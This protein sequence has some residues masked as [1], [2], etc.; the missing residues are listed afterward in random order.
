MVWATRRMVRAV[1]K[2]PLLI[3]S[4][5]QSR[6]ERH[7]AFEPQSITKTRSGPL[8][9]RSSV[10]YIWLGR[11]YLGLRSTTCAHRGRRQ[12]RAPMRPWQKVHNSRHDHAG[13]TRHSPRK[14][15]GS[16]SEARPM[17]LNRVLRNGPKKRT[18][19]CRTRVPP[20]VLGR[21]H[22]NGIHDGGPRSFV[23]LP[24]ADLT[25]G[26]PSR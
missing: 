13:N 11:G 2:Y 3:I 22:A 24:V 15:C 8:H 4:P 6:F 18:D 19:S 9:G 16:A 10:P 23:N 21:A 7:D 12:R 25:R 20:F 5:P 17:R 26:L 1:S 14:G